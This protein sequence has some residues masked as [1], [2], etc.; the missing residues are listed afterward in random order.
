[1]RE[2]QAREESTLPVDLIRTVALFLI[3]LLHAS[4]GANVAIDFMS[5]RGVELWWTANVYNSLSL[6]AVPLFVMLT[7][8]LLLSPS[9]TDEPLRVFFK[10]R[11]NRIGIPVIFWM[12]IYFLWLF[13][14]QN[15]PLTTTSLLQGVFAGPYNHFWYIYLLLG[16]YLATP[17]IRVFTAHANWKTVRYFL[18]LWVIGT[19]IISLLTLYSPISSEVTW[20]RSTVFLF[21]GIIG[22]YILGS[23][24]TKIK[25]RTVFL[26]LGF[27]LSSV[28]TILGTYFLVGSLGE[29]YGQFFYDASSIS[30][31]VA[32]VSLMLIFTTIPSHLIKTKHPKI[33]QGLKIISLN[34]LPIYLFH[35]IILETLRNGILGYRIDVTTLNP[36]LAIPL[37][38]IL[39]LG[40]CLAIIIPLKKIP[41]VNRIIG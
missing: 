27:A 10:K 18:V 3:I 2:H 12:I 11:W 38:A 15:Q 35:Y 41:Y 21:S 6:V 32:S 1:M 9:K 4:V 19:S 22:Y 17:F 31:L 30:I 25:I 34:T 36:I 23:Y 28:F 5:P 8:A 26:Y 24:L 7:G 39:T 16:L 29:V 33:S 37:L 14:S 20:F 13:Y 40:I